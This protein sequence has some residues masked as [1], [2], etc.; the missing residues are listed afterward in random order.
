MSAPKPD[1]IRNCIAMEW[2]ADVECG[3]ALGRAVLAVM[4]R[5][6]AADGLC[7]LGASEIAAKAYVKPAHLGRILKDLVELGLVTRIRR[8]GTGSGRLPDTLVLSCHLAPDASC[9]KEHIAPD[10]ECK[11]SGRPAEKPR[12]ASSLRQT[13]VAPDASSRVRGLDNLTRLV[14]STSEA[15]ASSAYVAVTGDEGEPIEKTGSKLPVAEAIEAFRQMA[16]IWGWCVPAAITQQRRS[17]VAARLREH[18]LDGWMAQLRL[19]AEIPFLGGDSPSGWRMDL[20]Y[21]SRPSGWSKIAEGNFKRDPSRHARIGGA[22]PGAGRQLTERQYRVLC[23]A[24][25]AGTWPSDVAREEIWN[26]P[27]EMLSEF[28]IRRERSAAA[29]LLDFAATLS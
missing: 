29:D 2:A 6:S 26:A 7:R 10:A 17:T 21:F 8:G 11:V 24:Y 27:A 22:T 23:G 4:A 25:N 9:A 19:A 1:Q 13:Q 5:N 14:I 16:K 12:D 28:G 20:D 3:S 18:G 15:K